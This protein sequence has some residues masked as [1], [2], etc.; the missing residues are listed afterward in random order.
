MALPQ[1]NPPAPLCQA[2]LSYCPWKEG[3]L[4]PCPVPA[5]ALGSWAGAQS[6]MKATLG[7]E[8]GLAPRPDGQARCM[9][10]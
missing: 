5:K 3:N 10:S 4:K 9:S 1:G 7:M 6:L 2:E 8:G